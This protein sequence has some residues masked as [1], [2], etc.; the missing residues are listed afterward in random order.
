MFNDKAYAQRVW[1][2]DK[3]TLLEA[4]WLEQKE[5]WY[6][7]LDPLLP[8][9]NGEVLDVGCGIGVYYELLTRK[10]QKYIGIDP[11]DNMIKRARERRPEGDFRIGTVYNLRFPNNRFDLVFCWSVLVHLPHNTVESAVKELWRVT[12]DHLFFN[13]YIGVEV[14]SFS[15]VGPWGEYLAVIDEWDLRKLLR[16]I[17][18]TSI[19][20][21]NYEAID[22]LEGK[23]F[24][25]TI[26][27][28]RK[29]K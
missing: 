12:K 21:V 23:R 22:L 18:P 10:A 15:A 24:Q 9:K 14:G 5:R 6:T 3:I 28:M 8:D 7:L 25:R 29:I 11:T 16:S 17:K 4:A 26:F 13:L 19:K 27:I 1:M 2:P 20:R